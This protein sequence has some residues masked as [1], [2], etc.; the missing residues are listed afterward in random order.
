VALQISSPSFRLVAEVRKIGRLRFVHGRH[1]IAALAVLFSQFGLAQPQC[2]ANFTYVVGSSS[3]SPTSF[4]CPPVTN[5][6]TDTWG[7]VRWRLSPI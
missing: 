1:L 4:A 3:T 5:T 6:T 2:I 7:G